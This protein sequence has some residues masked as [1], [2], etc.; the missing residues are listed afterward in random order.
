MRSGRLESKEIPLRNAGIGIGWGRFEGQNA[1]AQEQSS[2][3]QDEQSITSPHGGNITGQRTNATRKGG[4][5][6]Q[7]PDSIRRLV[8]G[9]KSQ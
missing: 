6:N 1:P 7:P 4:E 9:L 3:H 5:Q 8:G 2:Q